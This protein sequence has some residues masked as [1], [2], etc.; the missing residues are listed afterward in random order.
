MIRNEALLEAV[1]AIP[2]IDAH[3]H[4]VGGHLGAR[5]LH[6]I[7][8]YHMAVSDLYAAGCP[9]GARLTEYPNAPSEDEALRRLAEA[10]PFL[11]LVENT[12]TSWMVRIILRDLYAWHEP[13]TIDNWRRLD[14]MVRERAGDRSWHYEVLRRIGV[15][16]L[17]T[18]WARREQGQD[19]AILEYALEWAF[20]T[21]CQWG[22]YDTPL[23]ELERCWGRNPEPPTPI[24]PGGRPPVERAIVTLNDVHE[25]L[26]SY[27]AHVPKDRIFAIATHLSTDIDYRVVEDVE[28]ARALE[29]RKHARAE[30]RDIYASYVHEHLLAA[31]E[32]DSNHL[33]L[34]FSLAAEPLPYE[35]GSRI[36][37]RTLRQL[38]EMIGRHPGLKFQCFL[39]SR[40]AN[41]SLCTLCRE[42]PNLSLSGFWWHNFV[43][44]TIRQVLCERLDLLPLNKQIGFFSDAY[45][46]EWV[47]GKLALVRSA[48]ANVLADKIRDGQ[49]DPEL[50]LRIARA[51]LYDSPQSLL[52]FQPASTLT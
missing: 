29:R 40:H 38:G 49:Y 23:Y 8:L 37:Q 22:E 41:Q 19:D 26:D 28:M 27:V 11:P 24:G 47:Y 35:T 15:R 18:E 33:T 25:A 21:R 5:G 20:F 39:A 43:P 42:L 2:V 30:E 36:S 1:A 50:A 51:I 32:Q 17:G 31:L 9:S 12:S 6:D 34:Q 4:L 44:D 14:A 16:K 52:G 45:C 48:I 10:I 3:T 13:I 46:L 7:L